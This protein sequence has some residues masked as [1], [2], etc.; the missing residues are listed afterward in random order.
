MMNNKTYTSDDFHEM[1]KEIETLTIL[2]DATEK[3]RENN[4]AEIKRLRREIDSLIQKIKSCRAY[5]EKI[6]LQGMRFQKPSSL[7]TVSD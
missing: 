3:L 5:G 7:Q 4:V 2:L 6:L 1:V